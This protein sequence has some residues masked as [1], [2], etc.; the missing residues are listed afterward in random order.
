M[1]RSYKLIACAA[2]LSGVLGIQGCGSR[3]NTSETAQVNPNPDA[4]GSANRT[5]PSLSAADSEF[6]Q[7]AAEG[8][9]TEVELGRLA[10]QNA[11][12]DA[13]K[14][15]GQRMEQDHTKANQD[16]QQV[17][18]SKGITLPQSINDKHAAEKDRLAKLSG[19]RFDSEYMKEMVKDHKEDVAEF[20]REANNAQDPDVKAFGARTL[21]TLQD[22]LRM[23]QDVEKTVK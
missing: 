18:S 9:L 13:V 14:Q 16:L 12:S 11:S 15:F 21:P 10:Q 17:A 8:G 1:K 19:K 23:A 5:T 7:K 4:T 20:Q 22:H 6:V 3:T 2:I